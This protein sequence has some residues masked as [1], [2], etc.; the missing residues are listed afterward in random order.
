[1]DDLEGVRVRGINVKNIRCADD[2]VLIA[3][4]EETLQDLV[5]ALNR[6]CAERGMEINVGLG[7]TEVMELTTRNNDLIENIRKAVPQVEKYKH[8]GC[9]IDK[10]GRSESEVIKKIRMANSSFV[11]SKESISNY[12]DEF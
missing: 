3:D 6:A 2:M 10:D 8:L 7:K 11:K 9:V 1:M 5:S 12:G 4:T